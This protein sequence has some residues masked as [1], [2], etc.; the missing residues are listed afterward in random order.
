[1]LFLGRIALLP[2]RHARSDVRCKVLL[3]TEHRHLGIHIDAPCGPVGLFVGY[4]PR[5]S[6]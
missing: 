5:C 4:I 6:A 2:H 1:M 3:L